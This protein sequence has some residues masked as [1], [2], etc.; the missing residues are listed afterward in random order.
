MQVEFNDFVSLI[1]V[2]CDFISL[3]STNVFKKHYGWFFSHCKRY[4]RNKFLELYK[5]LLFTLKVC[6]FFLFIWVL[7]QWWPQ[8]RFQNT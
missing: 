5:A 2:P 4:S 6:G 7:F 3:I 8:M 1:L